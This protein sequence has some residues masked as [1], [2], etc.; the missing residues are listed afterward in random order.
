MYYLGLSLTVAMSVIT[1]PARAQ[2][3]ADARAAASRA[4]VSAPRGHATPPAIDYASEARNDGL[5]PAA[6]RN[7]RAVGFSSTSTRAAMMTTS[8]SRRR[9]VAIGA[10]VGALI[11]AAAGIA[12]S[13]PSGT[14]GS[15]VPPPLII[16]GGALLGAG[17]GV[18]IGAA[19][20][21]GS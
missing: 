8:S 4:S 20:P 15:M 1:T 3:I 7:A 10:G 5:P 2:H 9:H 13:I 6:S 16:A 18:L 21:S 11:G 12:L 17:I 19:A 14:E